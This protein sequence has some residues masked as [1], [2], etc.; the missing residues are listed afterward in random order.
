M[1]GILPSATRHSTPYTR[2]SS[3]SPEMSYFDTEIRNLFYLPFAVNIPAFS[4]PRYSTIDWKYSVI[5]AEEGRLLFLFH[6][7]FS[8]RK[9]RRS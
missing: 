9:A 6:V 5:G 4:T 7:E 3:S 8:V 1:R 2:T